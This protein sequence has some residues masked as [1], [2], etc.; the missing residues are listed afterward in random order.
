[1]S[2]VPAVA[3]LVARGARV[4]EGSIDDPVVLDRALDGADALYGANPAALSDVVS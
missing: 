1:M 3:D 4:V 2:S